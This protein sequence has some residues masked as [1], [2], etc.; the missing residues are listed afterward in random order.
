MKAREAWQRLYSRHGLQFGGS[1]EIAMLEPHLRP[2][3]LVLDAGCGDGKTTV[4]LARRADV[5]G[6]DFSREALISLRGQRDP[7]GK[8]N[9]VEC[10]ILELPFESEKFHAVSCVHTLS[11]ILERDR[12]RAA[13]ELRR[14]LAPGGHLFVE[15][16]GRAD[17]RFGEGEQV[18]DSSFARGNGIVTHYFQEGEIPSMFDGLELVSEISV[19]RRIS[20]GP[21]AGKRDLLRALLK[22]PA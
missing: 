7:D 9:L 16:F 8:V 17:L 19:L 18:E 2:D 21:R 22:K 3:R 13:S 1:G 4:A 11:H 10:N 15:G 14:V 20:F 6:C 5:V 12:L